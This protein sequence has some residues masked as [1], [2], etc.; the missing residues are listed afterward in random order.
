MG[1]SIPLDEMGKGQKYQITGFNNAESEYAIKL[2]KMGFIA[3]TEIELAPV[4]I[5]DPIMVQ[6]RGCRIALRK[7]ESRDIM[8]ENIK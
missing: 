3:G 4:D 7:T 2:H 1:K 5:K 6:I 8:V